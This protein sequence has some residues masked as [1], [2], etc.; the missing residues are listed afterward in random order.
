MENVRQ[1]QQSANMIHS[2]KKLFS[3]TGSLLF[4]QQD[5]SEYLKV[6]MK[7]AGF[8][9]GKWEDPKEQ[10]WIQT[11]SQLYMSQLR[12]WLWINNMALM[13]V[14]ICSHS[15]FWLKK[16]SIWRFSEF[17]QMLSFL[18]SLPHSSSFCTLTNCSDSP[19]RIHTPRKRCLCDCYQV[20]VL[21]RT[22]SYTEVSLVGLG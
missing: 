18:L 16:R 7:S 10:K 9:F 22:P 20:L 5:S 12:V 8:F 14:S 2:S 11:P 1:F 4:W 17:W 13:C 3:S 15:S 6:R 19:L 21:G